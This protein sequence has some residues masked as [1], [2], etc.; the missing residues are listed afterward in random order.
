MGTPDKKAFPIWILVI[1]GVTALGV[2]CIIGVSIMAAIAI[3]SLLRSRVAANEASAVGRLRSLVTTEAVWRQT[4]TD[5][6][7]VGDFWTADVSGFY[8]IERLPAGSGIAVS[9]IDV[10]LA[11]ADDDK[12][13]GGAPVAGAPLPGTSAGT[14]SAALLPLLQ[15]AARTGYLFR[16]VQT[17]AAGKP[18][19]T[20]P[21][22]DRLAWTHVESYAFQARPERYNATGINTFLVDQKGLIYGK[23]FG[24]NAAE[25]AAA[26]PGESPKLEGWRIVQ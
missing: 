21:D 5:R 23:D 22:G 4:D 18:Y 16:A 8:R 14:S 15:S 25:N 17:D 12:L 19:A 13:A 1:L 20:D 6:N 26:F 24:N 11:M 9:A 3:P 2:L 7:T 10:S